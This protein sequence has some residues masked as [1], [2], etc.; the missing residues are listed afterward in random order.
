MDGDLQ[1]PPRLIPDL[2]AQWR[3]GYDI[4]FTIRRE[5]EDA[6]A[7]KRAT[8]R[9]FYALINKIGN[10]SIPANSCPTA[11][12]NND[13]RVSIGELQQ[14]ALRQVTRTCP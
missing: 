6:S 4:V 7:L 8:A 1:H 12:V 2:L 13:G 3:L 11:D 9:A 14:A 5:T 10:V